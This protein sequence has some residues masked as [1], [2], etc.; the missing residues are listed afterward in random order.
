MELLTNNP[1]PDIE[2]IRWEQNLSSRSHRLQLWFEKRN[3][4]HYVDEIVEYLTF[5]LTSKKEST[6]HNTR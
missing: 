1:Y 6:Q 2:I 5:Y 3:A 4:K